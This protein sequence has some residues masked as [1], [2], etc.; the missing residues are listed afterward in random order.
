LAAYNLPVYQGGYVGGDVDEGWT[1]ASVVEYQTNPA[2]YKS[3]YNLGG[4]FCTLLTERFASSAR[5]CW[6][7]QQQVTEEPAPNCWRAAPKDYCPANTVQVSFRDMII[8]QFSNPL[9]IEM[10]M[11]ELEH[12]S[13]IQ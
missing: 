6:V 9:D 4:Q 3:N 8:S 1:F 2:N 7:Y 12:M 13:W 5:Q 11:A 10:A